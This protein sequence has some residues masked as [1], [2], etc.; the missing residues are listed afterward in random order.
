LI[1]A[2][3]DCGTG[4]SSAGVITASPCGGAAGAGS[5]CGAGV[6]LV[7][8]LAGAVSSSPTLSLR[9][10]PCGEFEGSWANA[11]FDILLKYGRISKRYDLRKMVEV[12]SFASL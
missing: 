5:G 9:T 6:E 7:A 12:A 3:R 10:E 1:G 11:D 2:E 8:G 4:V